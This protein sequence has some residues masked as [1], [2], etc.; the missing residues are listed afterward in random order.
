MYCR[1]RPRNSVHVALDV[2][3]RE[4]DP[5]DHRVEGCDPRARCAAAAGSSM[6]T[7]SGLDARGQVAARR[8]RVRSVR[9]MPRSTPAGARGADDTGAADEENP[10]EQLYQSAG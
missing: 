10:H 1:V 5:V 6:S 2:R 7:V 8:P 9:S 3:G 4:R